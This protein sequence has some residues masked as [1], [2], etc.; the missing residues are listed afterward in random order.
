M[1]VLPSSR[2][3]PQGRWLSVYDRPMRPTEPL[4]ER[5]ED[6]DVDQ[7]W[8]DAPY[9]NGRAGLSVFDGPVARHRGSA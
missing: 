2:C 6:V 8:A 4:G 3:R 9:P 7:Q 5:D 1:P